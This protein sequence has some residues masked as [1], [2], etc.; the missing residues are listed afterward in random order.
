[1]SFFPTALAY[2]HALDRIRS[3]CL[4]RKMCDNDEHIVI[5][6]MTSLAH[7]TWNTMHKITEWENIT[8]T[9]GDNNDDN[10]ASDNQQNKEYNLK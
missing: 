4:M 9:H 7:R 6:F 8:L 3:L 10:G 1:M 5:Q 2:T